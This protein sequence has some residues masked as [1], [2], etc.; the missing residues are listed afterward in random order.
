MSVEYTFK[1]LFPLVLE[2]IKKRRVPF[3]WG[4]PGIGK[5][6]LGRAVA[7]ALNAE[8]YVLD[9]PLLEPTSYLVAVP[10]KETKKV[11]LYTTGFLPVKG[12]AVV[13]VEDLSHAKGYQMVPL[14]QMVLDRRI[15]PLKFADDI[16]FIIT[17]NREE[18]LAGANPIPSPLLNRV[19]HFEMR[20]S[21]EEWVV[22]AKAQELDERVVQFINANKQYFLQLPQPGVKVWPTPRSWHALA[23]VIKNL[24]DGEIY[25]YALAAV[26][27]VAG[28][29]TSWLKYLR[30]VNIEEVMK[31]GVLPAELTRDKVFTIVQAV[32]SKVTKKILSQKEYKVAEFWKSLPNEYKLLFMKELIRYKKDGSFD[33]SVVEA[34]LLSTPEAGG[35]IEEILKGFKETKENE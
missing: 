1:E 15:G 19:L 17:G 16:S 14:M 22:W 29:F 30:S 24:P 27:A 21:P 11:E 35:Y 2:V 7:Q 32:A 5:S 23:D 31:K 4:P 33:I 3:I 10:E 34:F 26:G 13:L 25:P 28:A 8:L 12:P 20:P 6:T 9:A 18:D